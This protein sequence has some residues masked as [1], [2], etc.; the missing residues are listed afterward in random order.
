VQAQRV[1]RT[2]QLAL[3]RLFERVD[4]V[5]SPTLSIGAPALALPMGMT[6]SMAGGAARG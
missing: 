2:A 5:V 3:A 6:G 4:V 1:R